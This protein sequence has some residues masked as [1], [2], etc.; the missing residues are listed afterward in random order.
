MLEGFVDSEGVAIAVVTSLG[1]LL[2]SPARYL[3]PGGL[4]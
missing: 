1:L 3:A 2:H 4:S